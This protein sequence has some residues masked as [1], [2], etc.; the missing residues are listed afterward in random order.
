[1]I[2]KQLITSSRSAN[3]STDTG[4]YLNVNANEKQQE[5][6][7]RLIYPVDEGHPSRQTAAK[8]K[9]NFVHFLDYIH[10]HDL[11]VFL[12]L[13]RE[14]IQELVMKY[15]MSLRDKAEKKCTRGTVNNFIAPS[16]TS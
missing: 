1:M 13:G 12:D 2:R 7:R 8:Y 10:I 16:F 4:L 3:S 15:A 6:H 5:Q 11:D 9:K 14:A